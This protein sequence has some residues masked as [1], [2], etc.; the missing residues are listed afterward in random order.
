MLVSILIPTRNG[1][2]TIEGTIS[3]ALNQT[4]KNFEIIVLDDSINNKTKII[5]KQFKSSKIKYFK[6][7]VI[8]N[9]MCDNWE[10]AVKKSKG[11]M[12]FIVGDDDVVM[13][14]AIEQIDKIY[15]IHKPEIIQW[16]PH[17][18]YW[19]GVMSKY[20]IA[21]K[22]NKINITKNLNLEKKVKKIFEFGGSFLKELPM[23]YHSAISRNLVDKII[24]KTGRLFHSKQPDVFS[25][26]A[27][28]ALASSAVQID[29]A[30]TV[31][32][33]SL[34]SN[35]GSMRKEYSSKKN[36]EYINE[37]KDS[38]FH[39]SLPNDQR[40]MFFNATPDAILTAKELFPNYFN[41][42]DFNYSAMFAIF[43]RLSHYK[44]YS[45]IIRNRKKLSLTSGLVVY[46]FHGYL[47]INIAISIINRL[48]KL[49]Y[50]RKKVQSCSPYSWILYEVDK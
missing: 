14:N 2:A 38:N 32:A 7:K 43:V 22:S 9:S 46:K 19:P 11:D 23:I 48:R 25:G 20:A 16:A 6:T 26:M 33:W 27:F 10:S 12:M 31:N 35:S 34:R 45:W 29:E 18:F 15:S 1:A 49:F 40:M 30:L 44:N 24:K 21:L 17:V 3:S 42:F 50:L 4:N 36:L 8:G 28:A 37:F 41:K 47:L 39:K 5:V 13:P